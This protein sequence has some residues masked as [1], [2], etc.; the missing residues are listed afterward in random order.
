MLLAVDVGNT[1]TVFGTYDGP[2]LTEH[3]RVATER[4]HTGDELGALY[5]SFLDLSGISGISLSSTVP[6]LSR[7]YQEFASRYTKA[8]LLEVGP[9]AKT[10]IPVRYDDPRDVGPDRIANSVAAVERYGAPCIVVD[11]GTSTNFDVVSADAEYVGGVLA[12]GIEIS[13]D[14]LAARAARLRKVD[15]VE[16]E[17]VIGKTTVAALQSGVVYGFAGQVDGIVDAIRG[18]LGSEARVIAT[19]GLA[20]LIAPHSRTIERVDSFLT[21]EG[22]RIIWDRNR[23]S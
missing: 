3:W 6:Q 8:E 2:E 1:Q 12:P 23:A 20:E 15:F 18:E 19:G 10:G 16:P 5:R 7:S 14:A 22:L 4:T 21:L 9:G 17:S 11:F 13:M